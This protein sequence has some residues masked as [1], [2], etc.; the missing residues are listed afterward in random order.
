MGG[1]EGGREGG[2]E[3]GSVGGW[4]GGREGGRECGRVGGRKG[5]REFAL[6]YMNNHVHIPFRRTDL[7]ASTSVS[8]SVALIQSFTD[9]GMLRID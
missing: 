9:W 5:G 4:E 3:G 1:W 7:L 6:L 2:R 8:S